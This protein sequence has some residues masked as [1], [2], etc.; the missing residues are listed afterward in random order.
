MRKRIIS[1]ILTIMLIIK[2]YISYATNNDVE[3]IDRKFIIRNEGL[4]NRPYY[5]IGGLKTYC[6]GRLASR[7]YELK[8]YYTTEECLDLLEIDI[9]LFADAVAP[10]I[11][12]Y[13][14]PNQFT[15][16]IDFV[17]N[18]GPEAYCISTLHRDINHHNYKS[19]YMDFIIWDKVDIDHKLVVIKS[20]HDRR[21]REYYLFIR[22]Q[23]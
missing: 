14:T 1:I 6:V 15:A 4:V 16:V 22:K 23:S 8:D 7:D 17:Y 2:P 10:C 13:L 19:L 9:Q 3:Y 5:D 20:I 21:V 12:V 11:T 18:L